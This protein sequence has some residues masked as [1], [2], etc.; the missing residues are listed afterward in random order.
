MKSARQKK[1]PAAAM[2]K[3]RRR[4]QLDPPPVW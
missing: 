4:G 1:D 2:A 3:Y